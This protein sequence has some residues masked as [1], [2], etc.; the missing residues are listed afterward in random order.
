[1]F[2]WGRIPETDESSEAM[3]DRILY[4]SRVFITPGFIF[5]NNGARYLRI[6]LC[7]TE[8]KLTEALKRIKSTYNRKNI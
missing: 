5:G 4:G 8:E 2:I 7:A 1:M 6:S 3:A